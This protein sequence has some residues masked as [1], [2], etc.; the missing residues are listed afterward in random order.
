MPRPITTPAANEDSRFIEKAPA[1][2]FYNQT[3]Q[4]SSYRFYISDAIEEP[5]RY[6]QMCQVLRQAGERDTVYIHLN[7][8]GGQLD[9]TVQI[10]AAMKECRGQV[11]TVA[12]GIVASAA[13]L[14]FLAGDGFIVNPHCLM[15]L[16]NYSGGAFGKGH[17][18]V[19]QISADE[20]W[21]NRIAADYYVAFLTKRELQ[22]MIKGEDFWFTSDEVIERIERRVAFL[23]ELKQIEAHKDSVERLEKMSGDLAPY[24]SE[25]QN[26]QFGKLIQCAV[27]N[28]GEKYENPAQA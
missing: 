12:D 22:K 16:H 24:L 13:T 4:V 7:S 14:I 18:M 20:R 11:I 8:P 17:E 10:I 28:I 27:K 9:S 26:K 5:E 25:A 23:N 2:A 3:Q 15:M 21:F 19:A 6:H 1:V